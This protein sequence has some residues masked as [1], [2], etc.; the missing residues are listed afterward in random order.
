[1]DDQ[2]SLAPLGLNSGDGP[3]LDARTRTGILNRL[4][5]Y[6]EPALTVT[7]TFLVFVVA[8]YMN[9]GARRDIFAT[10]RFEFLLG[11]ALLVVCSVLL[12]A[13]PID[14]A[15]SKQITISI[16]VL[17]LAI[18]LQL[19]FAADTVY[20]RFIFQERVIK[21]AML[22][23][24]MC[25]LIRSPRTLRWFL[26]AFLFACLYVTQESVQGLI[27]GGLYWENQGVMRL[28]GSVRMYAHPNSLAGLGMGAVPFVI[29]LFPVLRNK[30][31]RLGLIAVFCTSV[32]CVIF[33]GSRTAYVAFM[34]FLVYWWAV[35]PNKAKFL[36]TAAV[37]S[38]IAFPFVPEQY[39]ERFRSITG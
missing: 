24:F 11:A 14:F 10:I 34:A 17:F 20:A 28:H 25:V 36:A 7:A 12:S 18:V 31:V 35:S 38:V 39:K 27:S 8:R 3:R 23:F 33:S 2:S 29:F 15:P 16:G 5:F 19:P 6:R 26:L 1:M 30:I 32:I 22:T 37:V 21:F 9:W 4:P 13:K